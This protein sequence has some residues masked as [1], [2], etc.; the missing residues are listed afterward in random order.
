VGSG[1]ARAPTASR[2]AASFAPE[3]DVFEDLAAAEQ[4]ER[5]VENV[6]GVPVGL[7]ILRTR[8][9]SS[10]AAGKPTLSTSRMIAPTPPHGIARVR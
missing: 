8:A 5:D 3:L 10:I 2:N 9:C 4:V 6:V 7:A 1:I